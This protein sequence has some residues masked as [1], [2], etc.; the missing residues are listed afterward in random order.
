MKTTILLVATMAMSV[1]SIS[2]AWRSSGFPRGMQKVLGALIVCVPLVVAPSIGLAAEGEATLNEKIM[3]FDDF[4]PFLRAGN[5]QR[6][7]FRGISP[8]YLTAY[9]KD[10]SRLLVEDG[11]PSFDDPLSASGPAQAIALVQH[12]P[13]VLV[14]QDLSD[15]FKKSKT[16]LYS[17]PKPMLQSAYPK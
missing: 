13:G 2:T 4:V 15:L 11:F 10:G 8:T 17:G 12:T 6:V 16:A 9:G 14:E 7:V 1:L 3:S 5:V